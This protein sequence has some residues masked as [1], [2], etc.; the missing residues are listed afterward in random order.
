MDGWHIPNSN[1]YIRRN[2]EEPA[3]VGMLLMPPCK[4]LKERRPTRDPKNLCPAHFCARSGM[5]QCVA[6]RS[7]VTC[8]K[9]WK[10]V[11]RALWSLFR[12]LYSV[13]Y[14]FPSC[15]VFGFLP[16]RYAGGDVK[17][18]INK[19]WPYWHV[20]VIVDQRSTISLMLNRTVE[21]ADT[22][23]KKKKRD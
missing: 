22:I 12:R 20:R 14:L 13:L 15:F 23:A 10:T 6:V 9:P 21:K 5:V 1:Y 2:K 3:T 18:R 19:G 7:Y 4:E 16:K 11:F 8:R 17:Q